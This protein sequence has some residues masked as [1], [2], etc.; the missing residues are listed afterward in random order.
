LTGKA[1]AVSGGSTLNGALINQSEYT[2]AGNQQWLIEPISGSNGVYEILNKQSG[3]ALDDTN[4]STSNGTLIQQWDYVGG[5]NQAW[6]FVPV[7]N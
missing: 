5:T 2:S 1:L 7:S 4:F 3:K 6:E